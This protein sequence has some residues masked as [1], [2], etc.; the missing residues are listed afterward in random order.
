M[1]VFIRNVGRYFWLTAFSAVLL[2]SHS[3]AHD[4]QVHTNITGV[5]YLSSAG[6]QTFLAENL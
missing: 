4:W 2:T 3:Y 6:L 1:N 5:A